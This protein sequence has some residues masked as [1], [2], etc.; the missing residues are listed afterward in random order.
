MQASGVVHLGVDNMNVV[1]H[2]GRLLD[3]HRSHCPSELLNDGD[4]ILLIDRMLEM[5]SRDTVRVTKVKGY[6][7]VE[8]VRVGQV[9]ELD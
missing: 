8:M 4:L 2:V 3:G 6:A 9:R 1:R 7:D 5:R